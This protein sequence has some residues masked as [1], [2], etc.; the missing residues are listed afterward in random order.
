MADAL[1]GCVLYVTLLL[2][3]GAGVAWDLTGSWWAG[4]PMWALVVLMLRMIYVEER[5]YTARR[6]HPAGE[7]E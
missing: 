5:R 4:G 2:A 6:R 3:C 1:Q 7:S